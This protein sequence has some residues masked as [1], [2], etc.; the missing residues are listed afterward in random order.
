MRMICYLCEDLGREKKNK[1]ITGSYRVQTFF[2]FATISYQVSIYE[3]QIR[4]TGL[5]Q[6]F[7]IG[8]RS[9]AFPHSNA[10]ICSERAKVHPNRKT[11]EN[12]FNAFHQ[13]ELWAAVC[14]AP[15]LSCEEI[16]QVILE[17]FDTHDVPLAHISKCANSISH[18]LNTF[19][20]YE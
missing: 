16:C 14:F 5:K 18:E 8:I 11:P 19:H 12:D 20:F 17:E 9:A 7:S 2:F 15:R 6:I 10:F 4:E 3:T 13:D 1:E